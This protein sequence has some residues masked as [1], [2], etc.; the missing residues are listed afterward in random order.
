MR[1][2]FALLILI[3]IF[4]FPLSA[5][6]ASMSSENF[7]MQLDTISVGGDVAASTNY[8]V[9]GTYGDLGASPTTSTSD[10]YIIHAGF[11]AAASGVTLTA[12]LSANSIALGSLSTGSVSSASQTL[13]VTTNSPTGYTTTVTEDGNLR[14]GDNDINDVGDGTVTA[15]SE[16][17]GLLTSGAA[18]QMNSADTAITGVAQTAASTSTIA[19]SEAITI[20]YKAAVSGN[21]GYGTYSHTV[22]FTTTA[23]Y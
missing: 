14:S 8:L 12:A 7:Q 19:T 5:G 21:T 13:T 23:N 11:Q 4:N 10:N 16:E 15:G 20:T 2:I 22:T 6:S 3:I 1:S 9:F 18:G 17:Y